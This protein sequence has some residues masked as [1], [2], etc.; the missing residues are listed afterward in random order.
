MNTVEFGSGIERMPSQMEQPPMGLPKRRPLM[1]VDEYLASERAAEERHVYIDGEVFA[2]AGESPAHGDITANLIA[3]LVSQLK[4]SPCRARTKDTKVRSG[5]IPEAGRGTRGMFSYPDAVVIC[6]EPEYH[7][8]FRDIVLN[9]TAIFE[10][11][12]PSTEA[13]DRGD[14]FLRYQKWNP[15]LKDYVLVSQN[16]AVVE[17]YSRQSDG[18]WEYLAFTGL[19]ATVHVPSI[20]CRLKLADLYDRVTFVEPTES[21]VPPPQSTRG[22]GP[23]S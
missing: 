1:T 9:P 13:L 11:L 19:E 17:R 21:I 12:S 14:K 2:M 4:G 18:T 5:P 16:Q 23:V 3:A 15:T 20:Q 22:T 10:V 6:G 8:S 7:D